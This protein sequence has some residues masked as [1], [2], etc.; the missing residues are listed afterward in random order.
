MVLLAAGWHG[1]GQLPP[2]AALGAIFITA[3]ILGLAACRLAAG[4]AKEDVLAHSDT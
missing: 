4:D 1:I 2:A 3:L